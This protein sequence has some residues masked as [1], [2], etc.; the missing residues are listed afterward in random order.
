MTTRPIARTAGVIVANV[1]VIWSLNILFPFGV[2]NS[3]V[4]VLR[5]L[6]RPWRIIVNV[7][8]HKPRAKRALFKMRQT[9]K[10]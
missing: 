5:L 7:Q 4:A 6:A 3:E 9:K 8:M 1:R 2:G 10:S